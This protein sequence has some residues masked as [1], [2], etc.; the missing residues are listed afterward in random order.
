MGKKNTLP[1]F[2]INLNKNYEE[3]LYFIIYAACWF[4]C[5]ELYGDTDR[6]E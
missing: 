2:L 4:I 1:L 5:S 6:N 3:N